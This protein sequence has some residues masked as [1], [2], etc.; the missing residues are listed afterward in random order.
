MGL[1]DWSGAKIRLVMLAVA[2]PVMLIMVA[3]GYATE[4]SDKPSA[5]CQRVDRVAHHLVIPSGLVGRDGA[6]D[7]NAPR[8][9]AAAATAAR[10][11]AAAIEDPDLKRKAL[12]FADA[13]HQF[14]QGNPSAPP[15][16][17]PDKN[18]MGG[19]QNSLSALHELKLACPNVGTDQLPDGFAR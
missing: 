11:E 7:P 13:L 19:Y 2:A 17:W 16:R 12:A 10:E 6:G 8:Q 1:P 15:N 14:G 9:A 18:Y 3:V 4:D 5:D